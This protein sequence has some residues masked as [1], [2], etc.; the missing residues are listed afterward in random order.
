MMKQRI[1][2]GDYVLTP[3]PSV[4]DFM[5]EVGVSYLT[6]R[7]VMKVLLDEHLIS[8][9][10]N[11]RFVVTRGQEEGEQPLHIVFLEHAPSSDPDSMAVDKRWINAIENAAVGFNCRIRHV[12]Y[13]HWNDPTIIESIEQFDGIFVIPLPEEMPESIVTRF[14]EKQRVVV[15]D[16]DLTHAGI[17]S[18][19]PFPAEMGQSL[20]NHLASLG[21][22]RIDCLNVQPLCLAIP[23]YIQQWRLWMSL[24]QHLGYTGKLINEPVVVGSSPYDQA[25]QVMDHVLSTGS[26]DATALFCTTAAGAIG[27]MHAFRLYGIQVGKDVAVC[28][29]NGTEMASYFCPTITAFNMFNIDACFRLC[30]QR[31]T[32]P[33]WNWDGA[34]SMQPIDPV[35]HIRESTVPE[36][37]IIRKDTA[38]T[39]SPIPL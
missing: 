4:R 25:F 15:I 11:G 5:V 16:G 33:E 7:K 28:T 13:K 2:H 24:H 27:A 38:K 29:I 39:G 3:F 34:L 36:S 35:L 10:P 8:H 22:T 18:I 31:M 21:H 23:E 26:F 32:E 17:P 20:L 30:L 9:A 12:L 37:L 6:A 19:M 1:L 14:R